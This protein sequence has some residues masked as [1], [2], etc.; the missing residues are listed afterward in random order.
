MAA[1]LK[2]VAA[3]LE[4]VFVLQPAVFEDQR[5]SFVKTYHID[6]FREAGIPFVARE[7]FFSTSRK[8]VVRGMHF[9]MPPEA[10][11]KLVYCPVGAVLDVVIDLRKS[12]RTF[13]KT[14]SRELSAK[15]REMLFIPIGFAHGFLSLADDTMMV[16][17]TSTVHSPANDAG[18]L[19]NSIGFEW[20]VKNPILSTRDK[21]F[22][23]L[24]DFKSPFGA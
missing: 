11:D 19:W 8:D 23:A 14:F 6:A 24:S 20:P 3:D 12:S 15:N 10:H 2:L 1:N 9:Q 17:Q 22:P 13:G 7:E 18:I 21:G 16:Y 4:G 5:G